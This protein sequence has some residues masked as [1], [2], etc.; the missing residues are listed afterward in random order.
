MFK[1][2]LSES[3]SS[4][5]FFFSL[6][7]FRKETWPPDVHAIPNVGIREGVSLQSILN[8]TKAHRNRPRPLPDREANQN[9]V[10]KSTNEMEKGEQNER[11]T[12]IRWRERHD[13]PTES[14]LKKKICNF[15]TFCLIYKCENLAEFFYYY[16]Y[17]TIY[18]Y[19]NN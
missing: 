16:Y 3:F 1:E 11:R 5:S 7:L 15:L 13:T 19:N 8:A 18:I 2:N 10:S 14:S 12:G 4:F 9:L 17:F 6:F